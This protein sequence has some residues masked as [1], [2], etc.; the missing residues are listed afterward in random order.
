MKQAPYIEELT[1]FDLCIEIQFH[2]PDIHLQSNAN[3]LWIQWLT[4][5]QMF[6][7]FIRFYSYF[8]VFTKKKLIWESG[9]E[10]IAVDFVLN[11]FSIWKVLIVS[12]PEPARVTRSVEQNLE[13]IM[14]Y[15]LRSFKFQASTWFFG[16]C[17]RSRLAFRLFEFALANS[18]ESLGTEPASH[19]D[20]DTQTS[21]PMPLLVHTSES[22]PPCCN[23]I[24]YL[25]LRSKRD[26][27][28]HLVKWTTKLECSYIG[29]L[30]LTNGQC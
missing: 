7:F 28:S 22:S 17:W 10:E 16:C 8:T 4:I 11:S 26:L 6:H 27:I 23:E 1:S 12:E 15:S 29:D 5:F 20:S 3:S 25:S 30:K 24:C 14:R 18:A 9:E 2:V 19:V 13:N 21:N